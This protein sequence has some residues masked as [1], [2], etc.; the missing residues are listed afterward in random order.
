YGDLHPLPA[1]KFCR[2]LVGHL[3]LPRGALLQ[4]SGGV[5]HHRPIAGGADPAGRLVCRL[6]DDLRPVDCCHF[7]EPGHLVAGPAGVVFAHA[8]RLDHRRG[9]RQRA[10]ARSRWHQRRGLVAGDQGRL[11]VAALPAGGLYLRR[12]AVAGAAHVRQE[13]CAVQSA[14]RQQ[15]AADLDSRPADPDM[16]WR[17]LRP[18]FQRRSERHGP[19]HADS[20]GHTAHGLCPEPCHARRPIGAVRRCRAGG[21]HA[22]HWRSG[23][24]WIARFNHSRAV[25]GGG[26]Q[27]G[28]QRL[29]P[30]DAHPA[31]L[32]H[33]LGVDPA[34][35]HFA[36]GEPVLAVHPDLLIST[37]LPYS[38]SGASAPF[39]LP[40]DYGCPDQPTGAD[41][42]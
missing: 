19:D 24:V 38:P 2:G 9:H 18:R 16:H 37:S 31:Q 36:V 30:A 25:I 22:D 12:A 35:G 28:R 26:G 29:R 11:L 33:G 21:R 6:R 14:G 3:Q 4:R 8:D 17:F 7:V 27:H 15:A 41:P 40:V 13:P 1:A 34:G 42:L 20:G 32:G 5:R 23:H 39:F 10:D